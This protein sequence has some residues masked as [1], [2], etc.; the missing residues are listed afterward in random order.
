MNK[1][2]D[3]S[4]PTNTY[5]RRPPRTAV[6]YL[7]EKMFYTATVGDGGLQIDTFHPPLSEGTRKLHY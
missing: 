3:N 6:G 1:T 5:L 4:P 7:I 2:P